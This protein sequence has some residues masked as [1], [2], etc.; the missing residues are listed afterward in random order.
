MFDVQSKSDD[1]L[2]SKTDHRK[3]EMKQNEIAAQELSFEF[4]CACLTI[5]FFSR[6]NDDDDDNSKFGHS[7]N[8]TLDP[9][10]F[11]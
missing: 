11:S 6:S 8:V 7:A 1:Q 5:L 10:I 3:N 4:M 2:T 9:G